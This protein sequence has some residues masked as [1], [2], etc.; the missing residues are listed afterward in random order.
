MPFVF[1]G[2]AHFRPPASLQVTLSFNEWGKL[3]IRQRIFSDGEGRH[4]ITLSALWNITA[5]LESDIAWWNINPSEWL[6]Q[7]I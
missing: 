7:E 5:F 4:G 2:P 3:G 1:N 6:G